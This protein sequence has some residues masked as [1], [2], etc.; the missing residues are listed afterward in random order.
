MDD[1]EI[2]LS[3]Q[4]KYQLKSWKRHGVQWDQERNKKCS[5]PSMTDLGQEDEG[6]LK[7]GR[8]SVVQRLG[9]MGMASEEAGR[10][11]TKSLTSGDKEKPA[12]RLR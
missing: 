4:A 9:E 8:R 1:L 10:A 5:F 12:V 3:R 6:H 7:P 11:G 2:V